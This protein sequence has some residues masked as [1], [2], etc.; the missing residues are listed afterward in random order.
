MGKILDILVSLIK[1][2]KPDDII[3]FLN[4]QSELYIRAIETGDLQILE[5]TFTRATIDYVKQMAFRKDVCYGIS[6]YRK[7]EWT[8]VD[9]TDNILKF[10]MYLTHENIKVTSRVSVPLGDDLTQVW[11][12][13]HDE[14]SNLVM[15]IYQEE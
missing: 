9:S 8:L 3:G 4:K 11:T 14:S 13:S 7:R 10:I 2:E 5:K 1:S 12:I 6:K 15:D